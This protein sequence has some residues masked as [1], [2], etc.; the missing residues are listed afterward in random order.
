[1]VVQ[2][3]AEAH[4]TMQPLERKYADELIETARKIGAK[5][6]GILAADE[7]TG[8]IGKRLSAIHLDNSEENRRDYRS[9]LFRS[10]GIENHISG[11]I[12]FEET[13]F[14][15]AEDGSDVVQALRDKNIIL[16]IKTDKGTRKLPFSDDLYTQGLTDLGERCRKYYEAG[17]RFA[18]WRAVLKIVDNQIS[19][20][21]INETAHTLARYAAISQ[22]YGL[23][24]IVEPE[25]LMDG[26]H[27]LDVCQYWTEK[28]LA[29][30]YKALNDQNV[31]LEGTLLK[32]NM[33]LP[34]AENKD[35]VA[36]EQIGKATVD[37][38]RRAVPAAVPTVCFL[39]GGQSEEEATRNLNAVNQY[40]QRKGRT[41]YALT[42][43]FGR[44]LQKSCLSAWEGKKE[45][46]PKAQE[47][48]VARAKANGEA[49]Q[50][51]Y[52]GAKGA[53]GS[54]ESLYETGYTY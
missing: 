6:K 43:S 13:L 20:Q 18:K 39:S 29:A 40:A 41:P 15:K 45:N 24:P 28:T 37:A 8:T 25:I 2:V 22:E 47:V 9:F 16:G 36:P 52:G 17:A 23:A 26:A 33:V 14:Q 32:P 51:V 1:M 19:P 7:S 46:I 3:H 35:K 5:G 10:K 30:C 42:F 54:D 4:T 11:V 21:S 50:G 38:L 31:L 44:A 34:G 12:L 49:Q 27:S 48:F 53:A